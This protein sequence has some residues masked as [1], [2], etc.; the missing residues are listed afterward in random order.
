VG[1]SP[2]PQPQCTEMAGRVVVVRPAAAGAAGVSPAKTP[3]RRS[4]PKTPATGVK[5][6]RKTP[7]TTKIRP[8]VRR[9]PGTKGAPVVVDDVEVPGWVFEGEAAAPADLSAEL[10]EVAA[11]DEEE[12]QEAAALRVMQQAAAEVVEDDVSDDEECEEEDGDDQCHVCNEG[13][14]GDVLLLCDSCDNA[15]HLSCCDPPLKRV[16]KGNWYCTECT[17][18]KTAAKKVPAA[19]AKKAAEPKKAPAKA[20]PA[21]GGKKAAAAPPT[22]GTKRGRGAAAVEG[23]LSENV[24]AA[25]K[26]KAAAKEAPAPLKRGARQEASPAETPKRAGRTRR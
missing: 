26:T 6:A 17:A 22:A 21:R 16:P 23:P 20:A 25:K 4:L 19:K 5:S 1:Y 14:E 18:K 8:S 13:E 10:A 11:A 12:A 15:C 24:P 7:A 9:T 3:G 2:A